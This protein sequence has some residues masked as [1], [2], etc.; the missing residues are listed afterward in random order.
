ME[1]ILG[2]RWFK[3]QT[4]TST[5]LPFGGQGDYGTVFRVS[6]SGD[7]KVLVNFDGTNGKFP[8]SGLIQANDGNF[9]GVA[10]TAA[11]R[12]KVSFSA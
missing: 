10:A 12:I 7:F 9:Y 3:A 4:T 8:F 2:G 6:S 5:E 1:R 11:L